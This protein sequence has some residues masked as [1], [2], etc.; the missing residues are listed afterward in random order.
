MSLKLKKTVEVKNPLGL[1]ARPASI[2]VRIANKFQSDI[3]VMKDDETVNGKSMMGILTLAVEQGA[4]VELEI[5]G[6]DAEQAMQKLEAFLQSTEE[7][8]RSEGAE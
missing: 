3:H 7:P 8:A 2:F 1:H 4:S 5:I 6:S